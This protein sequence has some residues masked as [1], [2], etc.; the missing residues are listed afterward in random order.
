MLGKERV[1]ARQGPDLVFRQAAVEEGAGEQPVAEHRRPLGAAPPSCPPT[2]PRGGLVGGLFPPPP[3]GGGGGGGG[4]EEENV[5]RPTSNVQ[6]PTKKRAVDVFRWTLD[7][8]RLGGSP[9][10]RGGARE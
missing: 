1:D 5:Q 6:R 4:G 10:P 3:R 9:W 2:G 8:G 7:V